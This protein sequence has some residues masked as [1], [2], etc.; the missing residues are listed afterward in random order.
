MMTESQ[1]YRLQMKATSKLL[2][3][4]FS[5]VPIESLRRRYGYSEKKIREFA[6]SYKQGKIDIFEVRDQKKI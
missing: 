1:R 5:G 3:E 4:Y 2:R 6:S